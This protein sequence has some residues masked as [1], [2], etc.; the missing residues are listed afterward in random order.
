MVAEYFLIQIYDKTLIDTNIA[1]RKTK[2]T[3][4][5]RIMLKKYLNKLKGK[6]FY[7]LKFDI[8]KYFYNISHSI[9]KKLIRKK[10]QDQDVLR[11]LDDIIDSIDNEYINNTISKLKDNLNINDIPLY[12]KGYGL[13]IGNLTSQIL[14]IMYL[15]ELDRY[16]KEKLKIKYYI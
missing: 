10:I 4:Y 16:I 15:D 14:A 2:G 13:P 5:G 9:L 3:N 6:E 1:T 11:I 8:S 7:I 12:R